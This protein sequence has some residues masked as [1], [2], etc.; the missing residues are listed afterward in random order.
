MLGAI[1]G[2]IVG[3]TRER[4]NVKTEDFEL[5]PQGS[6]FTDDTVMTLAVAEWLMAD[7]EHKSETLVACMQRL[8]RKYPNAGYGGMF[9]Q[10]LMSDNPQP[11]NSFGNGSAM[12]VSPVGFYANSLDEA[13]EL[14]RISASVTHNHPEGIKGAQAIAGCVYLRK[15]LGLG[16]D[17]KLRRFVADRIGYNLDVRLEDIR[18]EYTF[19]VTCQGSV[20]IAIM[21]YL[22]RSHE[23]AEEA[24][25]LAISMGG[26]SDT[27][28]AMT[29]SIAGI[30]HTCCISSVIGGFS[31]ELVK[32]CR[33]LL[34]ADLLDIND[35]FCN[36]IFKR[37]YYLRQY[38]PER[39]SELKKDEIFV[40]GSNLAGAHGGGAA[41]L[42]QKRFG[43]IWGQG[44]GPQGQCY[45]IPTMQGGVET[46]RPYVDEFIRFARKNAHLTFLVTKIGCGTAGFR[47][48]EIAPLFR[49]AID[50]E[51]IILPKE[52]VEHI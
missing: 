45:A 13:L 19:D 30:R 23:S 37:T 3:S 5:V 14:A 48:E 24:L 22:Q 15:V 46:I 17:E 25:R 4:Y 16:T 40:F 7:P 34:P 27:I 43:A 8:G 31:Y 33:A 42:A 26:D 32:Q 18:D 11:Y 1:I 6:S 21:A 41:W 20:P 35:R 9:Y 52:F 47:D 39:I 50:V 44:V 38:T 2:D 28:G 49:D 10:W 36:W 12:R 29:A 51:N